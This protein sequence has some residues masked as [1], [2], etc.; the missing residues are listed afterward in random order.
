MSSRKSPARSSDDFCHGQ[1]GTHTGRSDVNLALSEDVDS[2]EAEAIATDL[3][4]LP[5][6]YRFEVQSLGQIQHP[7]LIEH[8]RR[9]GTCVYAR[10]G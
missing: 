5:I 4:A 9:V 2:L 1:I 7:P 6:P 8:I 10:G 3:D